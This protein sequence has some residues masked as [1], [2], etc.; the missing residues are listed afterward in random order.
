[1][2]LTCHRP[3]PSSILGCIL[4]GTNHYFINKTRGNSTQ[5]AIK[6]LLGHLN[7]YFKEGV[8][9]PRAQGKE[10]EGL[11]QRLAAALCLGVLLN[12]WMAQFA[13]LQNK[14]SNCACLA[15]SKR[16]VFK[17]L[18]FIYLFIYFWL[19]W[20][21]VASCGLSLVAVS[22]GYSSLR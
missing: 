9:K 15:G 17:N 5:D 11:V 2:P 10:A 13:H 18:I 3:L 12:L 8:T 14:D 21:F 7:V 6:F 22:R 1:M 4:P 16:A 19:R 20:V